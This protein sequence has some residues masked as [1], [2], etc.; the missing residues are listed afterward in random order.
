[1]TL[2]DHKLSPESAESDEREARS[3]VMV[4]ITEIL[5]VF[6]DANEALTLTEVTAR[7]GLPRSTAFRLLTQL[8]ELGW[9]ERHHRGYRIGQR[10]VDVGARRA[11]HQMLREAAHPLLT[12]LHIATGGIAHLGV[13]ELDGRINFLDKIGLVQLRIFPSYVGLRYP[14][15]RTAVGKAIL[16][17]MPEEVADDVVSSRER[18]SGNGLD[19]LRTELR[20]IRSRSGIAIRHGHH[21]DHEINSVGA[22]VLGPDGPVGGISIGGADMAVEPFMAAVLSASRTISARLFPQWA[23]QRWG[24]R[25][26]AGRA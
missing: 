1:M 11:N 19:E 14:V 21:D 4:R 13:L 18:Q 23:R 3:P 7:T 17:A 10:V 16:A 5:D 9:L 25:P 15:E 12:E 2:V 24:R 26:V 6:V 22:A 20:S 8:A